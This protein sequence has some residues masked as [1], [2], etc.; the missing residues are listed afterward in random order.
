MNKLF[1]S[2]KA[3]GFESLFDRL[4]AFQKEQSS[5]PPFDVTKKDDK[6]F[7][8]FAVAGLTKEDIKIELE[9]GFLS[10]SHNAGEEVIGEEVLHKG[11]AK[12]SFIQRFT[13]SEGIVINDAKLSN[14]LLVIELQRIIPED[15]KPKLIEITQED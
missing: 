2:P 12:R 10:V 9:N 14:G 6:Y 3:L 11:I 13:L 4:E 15:K 7:I 1:L 5:Y 8:T